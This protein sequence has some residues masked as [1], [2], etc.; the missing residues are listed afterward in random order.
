MIK[1]ENS[2]VPMSGAPQSLDLRT[3][4]SCR[5]SETYKRHLKCN[6]GGKWRTSVESRN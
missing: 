4:R 1:I 5:G 2:S 3:G 6:A